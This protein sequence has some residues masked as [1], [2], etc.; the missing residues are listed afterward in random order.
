MCV[1][2]QRGSNNSAKKPTM[3]MRGLAAA[4]MASKPMSEQ[5][6]IIRRL[7]R[8]PLVGY[9]FVFLSSATLILLASLV[10]ATTGVSPF[11]MTSLRSVVNVFDYFHNLVQKWLFELIFP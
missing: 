3:P 5:P 8:I 10:K 1:F 9:I 7:N 11:L 2:T 4:M 6:K